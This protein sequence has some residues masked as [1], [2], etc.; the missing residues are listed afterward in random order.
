M[1][2]YCSVGH[3]AVDLIDA[4]QHSGGSVLF[5]SAL[6]SALD[7]SCGVVTAS[8]VHFPFS[9]FS[10]IE[11]SIQFS[12]HT[13]TYQHTYENEQRTSKLIH[14]SEVISASSVS[15][16]L[17]NSQVVMLAPILDEIQPD[18]ISIF[19]TEWIGLTPQGWFRRFDKDGSMSVATSFFSKLPKKIKLIVVSSED[20]APD[21]NDWEWIKESAEVAVC[22]MGKE[23]YVLFHSGVEK[24]Y[25]PIEVMKEKNPTGCG[26]IFATALL[27]L[28]SKGLTPEK[29][30]ELA[31]NAA[32][33]ASTE[34]TLMDSIKIAADSLKTYFIKD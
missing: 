13:T 33:L 31:G 23:G 3:V 10:F 26:D 30:C 22:T 28:L 25:A 5:G 29:A 12:P 7:M 2:Q 24:K 32:G 14:K 4:K 34:E 18:L 6:A 20:L 16:A 27:L 19:S 17:R 11:W 15:K 9:N 8:N 1:I 21:S